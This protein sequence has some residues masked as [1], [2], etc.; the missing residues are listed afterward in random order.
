M[1]LLLVLRLP[2]PFQEKKLIELDV[3]SS[4]QP[5]ST[6]KR[7]PAGSASRLRAHLHEPGPLQ[8]HRLARL[9]PLSS[10]PARPAADLTLLP[11]GVLQKS[12]WHFD[13]PISL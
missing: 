3:A 6:H 5:D 10:T 7:R 12:G 9:P 11:D 2:C 8:P 1:K 4:I 13:E